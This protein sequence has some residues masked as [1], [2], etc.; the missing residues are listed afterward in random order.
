MPYLLLLFVIMICSKSPSTG[1]AV[2]QNPKENPRSTSQNCHVQPSCY[3]KLLILRLF[4]RHE[5]NTKFS[6]PNYLIWIVMDYDRLL[7][8]DGWWWEMMDYDCDYDDYYHG[9]NVGRMPSLGSHGYRWH[10]WIAG[11]RHWAIAGTSTWN[12]GV[13]MGIPPSHWNFLGILKIQM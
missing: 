8:D 9:E 4:L 5:K 7:G 3:W 11:L 1:V 10:C 12:P 6:I 13:P 2:R